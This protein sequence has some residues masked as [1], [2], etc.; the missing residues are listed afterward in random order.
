MRSAFTGGAAACTAD[1]LEGLE[2]DA[3]RMRDNLTAGGGRALAERVSFALSSSL[4]RSAAIEVVTA[5][6]NDSAG[7]RDALLADPR[8]ELTA[9]E[10]DELLAPEGYLG[11]AEALVDRALGRYA[12]EH[13]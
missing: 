9:A 3:A 12:E 11:S 5:A 10:V 1:S 4:G 8:T 7:F 13:S 6:S 2:V